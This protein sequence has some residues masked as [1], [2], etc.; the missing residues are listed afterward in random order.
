MVNQ[1]AAAIET[2]RQEYGLY[3]AFDFDA[4][5]LIAST[6]DTDKFVQTLSSRDTEGNLGSFAGNEKRITFYTVSEG[7]ISEAYLL[8]DN[9][10]G[11][12]IA[13]LVDSNYDGIIK[14]ATGTDDDYASFPIVISGVTAP[15]GWPTDGLRAGVAIYSPGPGGSA[16]NI[17]T[18]W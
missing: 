13:V 15:P 8:V 10:G 9:F 11:T 3:P 1:W 2:F 17:T 14:V 16:G 5:A 6:D 4:E 12:P 7:E 18:T